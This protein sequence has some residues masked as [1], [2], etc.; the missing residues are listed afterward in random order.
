MLHSDLKKAR[1]VIAAIITPS[2][3]ASVWKNLSDKLWICWNLT[4]WK[5]LLTRLLFFTQILEKKQIA[6]EKKGILS[7]TL[8]GSFWVYAVLL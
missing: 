5:C 2:R 4:N 8:W 6:R 3:I 1:S 7:L